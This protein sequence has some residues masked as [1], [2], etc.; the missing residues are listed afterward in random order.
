MSPQQRTTLLLTT[1]LPLGVCCDAGTREAEGLPV[2]P[3]CGELP[4]KLEP[5]P[6]LTSA[7]AVH[8]VMHGELDFDGPPTQPIDDIR[9][10]LGSMPLS[11]AQGFQSASAQA[12][13]WGLAF[14]V[15]RP[16]EPGTYPLAETLFIESFTAPLGY[17]GEWF[18]PYA[19]TLEIIDVDDEGCVVGALHDVDA[20]LTRGAVI[21]GAFVATPCQSECARIADRSCHS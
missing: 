5:I 17:A 8:A 6:G 11:C 4:P 20:E 1:L 14:S 19:G 18:H 16:L 7:L 21:E 9:F 13:D 15:P 10:R 3:I 2:S 12:D